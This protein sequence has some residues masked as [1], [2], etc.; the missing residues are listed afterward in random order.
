VDVFG[1]PEGFD[2]RLDSIVRT[3][4]SRLRK[5]IA[6]YYERQGAKETVRI[7]AP[8]GS[9]QAVFSRR[10]VEAPPAPRP[11]HVAEQPEELDA[12]REVG[13]LARLGGGRP[14]RIRRG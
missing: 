6:L 7:E 9:Y 3:Q 5:Q 2:P 11:V 8:P 12:D 10:T 13:W 1:R 14:L 4:A